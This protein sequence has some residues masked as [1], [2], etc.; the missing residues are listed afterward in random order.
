M[1]L[2]NVVHDVKKL[3]TRIKEWSELLL[4]SESI[5]MDK[6]IYDIIKS[7]NLSSIMI[8][9]RYALLNYETNPNALKNGGKNS[10]QNLCKF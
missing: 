7:I 6:E 9:N 3:N 4:E 2:R 10:F 1:E 5:Q 8:V